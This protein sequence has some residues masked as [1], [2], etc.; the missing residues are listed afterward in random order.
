MNLTTTVYNI[1]GS[2]LTWYISIGVI[3]VMLLLAGFVAKVQ[4]RPGIFGVAFGVLIV[5]L[6]VCFIGLSNPKTS[7]S[8]DYNT[9]QRIEQLGYLTYNQSNGSYEYKN[10]HL[11]V[12]ND[13]NIGRTYKLSDICLKECD[14]TYHTEILDV[15]LYKKINL[16]VV[17][18]YLVDYS[19]VMRSDSMIEFNTEGKTISVIYKRESG[20]IEYT[21]DYRDRY[22]DNNKEE[23]IERYP[24]ISISHY[25]NYDTGFDELIL[26]SIYNTGSKDFDLTVINSTYRYKMKLA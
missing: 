19:N 10:M 13:L 26:K 20:K 18:R 7:G 22:Y 17:Y 12:N 9:R 23:K 15:F 14:T 3:V 24:E 6:I 16:A 4:K 8:F 1:E 2:S 25:D 21:I 11:Y 5:P